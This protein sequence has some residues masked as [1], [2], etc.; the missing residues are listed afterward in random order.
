MVV[1]A[2]AGGLEEAHRRLNV[3]TLYRGIDAGDN[4]FLEHRGLKLLL[5][6]WAHRASSVSGTPS[7]GAIH[8][9]REPRQVRPVQRAAR[10]GS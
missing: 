7:H 10:E 4:G 1:K 8:A 5:F 9:S 6:I 3:V 2:A